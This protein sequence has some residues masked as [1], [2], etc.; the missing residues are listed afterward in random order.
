MAPDLPSQAAPVRRLPQRRLPPDVPHMAPTRSLRLQTL[1]LWLRAHQRPLWWAQWAVVAVYAVLLVVPALLPLPGA[2]ARVWSNLTLFAQFV[3]WG[4]WWPGV[5]LSVLLFGRLWCGIF[6]P[7]GALTAFAS[8][9][10]RGRA[11]PH[12]LRWPGWPFAAFALTTVYGQMISVYHVP[13]A[14]LLILGASTLA[15]VLTGYLYGREKRVWCRYLCP[16]NG[17][18]GLLARLAPVHFAV[19]ARAWDAC[20]PDRARL[21][22]FN[23]E[24]MVPV[25]T[26]ESA[27]PCHMCGRCAGF[28]DAV[29]LAPRLPGSEIVTAGARTA[30]GWDSL[31]IIAG[32]IGLATAAFLWGTSPWFAALRQAVP[33]G[34]A[35]VGLRDLRETALPWWVLASRP[36][37]PGGATVADGLALSAWLAGGAALLSL[38]VALPLALATRIL[39]RW[40]WPRFHHLA[41]SLIPVAACGL[42][43][44]LSDL[45]V[46]LLRA[47]G[48][49][50]VTGLRLAVA[51]LAV[52]G[53]LVLAWQ[54]ARQSV[55]P[56]WRRVAATGAVAAALL[57]PLGCWGLLFGW[58]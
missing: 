10:G 29:T 44:G 25:R 6:C 39:G 38:L 26:M 22:R 8:R 19:D 52:A 47:E 2:T 28:R 18:F 17:V 36:G 23:C 11:I 49:A 5:L 21:M 37:W 46:T 35:E 30:T 9:H 56:P 1:G 34:L 57:P 33:Q 55:A 51:G 42:I 7:E 45:T 15:A 40:S 31:L 48:L 16:V 3:F 43:L 13:Q 32:M 54:I 24:P 41:Q 27:A 58:W 14:T 50:A 4:L 12:W 20:A 53:S